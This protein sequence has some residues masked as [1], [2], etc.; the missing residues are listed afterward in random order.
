MSMVLQFPT[1]PTLARA[2]IITAQRAKFRRSRAEI[3]N[4][5]MPLTMTGPKDARLRQDLLA[6]LNEADLAEERGL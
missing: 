3:C 1:Y 5:L 4:D 6:E 2:G